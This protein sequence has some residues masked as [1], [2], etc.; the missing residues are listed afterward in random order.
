LSEPRVCKPARATATTSFDG[1]QLR[2]RL[3]LLLL[4]PGSSKTKNSRRQASEKNMATMTTT[5]TETSQEHLRDYDIHLSSRSGSTGTSLPAG[6][7][8]LA[9]PPV[10]EN[11]PNWYDQ[12]RQVP[13][14]RPVNRSLDRASRP[15]G[16]NPVESAFV[17]HMMHGVW[18]RG[19]CGFGFVFPVLLILISPVADCGDD[20]FWRMN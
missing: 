10:V 2:R 1:P 14:F 4:Q 8:S 12:H 5:V 9:S 15:Y 19:V 11:P 18:L 16:S 7:R 13:P 17:F 3:L 20:T 6:G